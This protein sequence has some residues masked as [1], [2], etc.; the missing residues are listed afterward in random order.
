MKYFLTT[1]IV[2]FYSHA[3]AETSLSCS[4]LKNDRNIEFQYWYDN[5]TIDKKELKSWCDNSNFKLVYDVGYMSIRAPSGLFFLSQIQLGSILS[6]TEKSIKYEI[7][8][9]ELKDSGGNI[10]DSLYGNFYFDK[11][12]KIVRI[13]SIEIRY[14]YF[15]DGYNKNIKKSY[16]KL[17]CK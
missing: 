8:P 7:I 3:F 13:D 12:N 4:C 15:K 16:M 11:I 5:L 10:V 17:K 2:F 9:V 6:E 14:F 1:L